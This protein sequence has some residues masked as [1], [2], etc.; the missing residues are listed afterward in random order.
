MNII[1]KSIIQIE[2]INI[3]IQW[4]NIKNIYL[5]ISR[6]NGD[7]TLSV[8]QKT[9]K[10]TIVSFLNSKLSWIKSHHQKIRKKQEIIPQKYVD[11]DIIIYLGNKYK[12]KVIN[13]TQKQKVEIGNLN[14]IIIHVSQNASA[15]VKKKIIDKFYRDKLKLILEENIAKWEKIIGVKANEWRIKK[16]KTR[17]GTCNRRARRIWINLELIKKSQ[18]CIDYIIVHELIHFIEKR[19]NQKFY[20]LVEKYI[21]SWKEI[22]KELNS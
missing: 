9:E 17:W 14:K 15:Q 10:T 2:E 8:P 11:G 22:K 18:R 16:M 12:L 1:Q 4:K 19:H 13:T 20:M 3:Q 7:I 21:P 5:K 6:L